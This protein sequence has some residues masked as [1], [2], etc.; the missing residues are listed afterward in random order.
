MAGLSITYMRAFKVGDRVR[1]GD[2]V[3]DVIDQTLLV[4]H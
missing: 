4:T 1:I 3:G 2:S